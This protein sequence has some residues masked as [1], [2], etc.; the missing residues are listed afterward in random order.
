MNRLYFKLEPQLQSSSC[1]VPYPSKYVHAVP[2]CTVYK[3]SCSK[4]SGTNWV[5]V[6]LCP[7]FLKSPLCPSLPQYFYQ[8][9]DVIFCSYLRPTEP[10]LASQ[11]IHGDWPADCDEAMSQLNSS[12]LSISGRTSLALL[13]CI[14]T[15]FVNVY[16]FTNIKTF[17]PQTSDQNLAICS[18]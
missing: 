9:E 15:G 17:T 8:A 3:T 10:E 6:N 1:L 4:S 18:S 13:V 7:L 2:N 14:V 16:S 5:P 12:C 11:Y